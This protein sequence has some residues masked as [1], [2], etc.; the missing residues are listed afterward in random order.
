MYNRTNIIIN[1][2]FI[3]KQSTEKKS[4]V[5]VATYDLNIYYIGMYST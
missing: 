4:S 5:Q 2:I 3:S 1:L